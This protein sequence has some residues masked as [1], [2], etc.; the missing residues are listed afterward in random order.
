MLLW[1]VSS[2]GFLRFLC[3]VFVCVPFFVGI[4][5]TPEYIRMGQN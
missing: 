1:Y 5:T 2:P 3:G 4:A